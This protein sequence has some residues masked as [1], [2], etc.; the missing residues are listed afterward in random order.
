MLLIPVIVTVLPAWMSDRTSVVTV[1]TPPT[2]RSPTMT[3]VFE[4]DGAQPFEFSELSYVNVVE[5]TTVFTRYVPSKPLPTPAIVT[6]SLAAKVLA[7]EVT[8]V[9]IFE[10]RLIFEMVAAD[11]TCTASPCEY[12]AYSAKLPARHP[13]IDDAFSHRIV[14]HSKALPPHSGVTGPI[15]SASETY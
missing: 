7:L 3:G 9:A 8:T 10:I 15:P 6:A 2:R 4:Q 12:V 14:L 5:L 13:P 11:G 1:A